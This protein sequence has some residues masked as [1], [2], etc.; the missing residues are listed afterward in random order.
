MSHLITCS[1]PTVWLIK[2][3]T[4]SQ[5]F[6]IT[7]IATPCGPTVISSINCNDNMAKNDFSLNYM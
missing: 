5:T 6:K 2:G 3:L 7:P 1:T 4:I